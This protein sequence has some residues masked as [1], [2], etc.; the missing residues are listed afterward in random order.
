MSMSKIVYKITSIFVLLLLLSC[1]SSRE[2]ES[3]VSRMMFT[4]QDG[5]IKLVVLDPGHFHASLLQKFP[6]RQVNDTV[7]VYAPKGDELNQYL[8]SIESYNQRL[9]NPT[10]WYTKVYDGE[11][12]LEKM[13]EEKKGNVV[14]LAGNN[15]KKTRYIY[16]SIKA[17]LHVLSDKPM[18]INRESFYLLVDAYEDAQANELQLYD[19]MTERYEILNTLTRE[20]IGNSELFGQLQKGTPEEQSVVMENVHHYFKDVSGS[21]LIRPAWFYDVEQ[22]GEA[23]ADVG[24]HL[25]DL[26]NWQCFADE[27]IDY[28]RDVDVIYAH[29]W[30]TILTL[31]DF[32]RSTGL[33]SFPEFLQRYVND[34][35]ELEVFGNGSINYQVKGINIAVSALW[36]YEAPPGGGDTYSA[37]IKGT[38]ASIEIKQ[39][40][41]VNYIKELFIEKTPLIDEQTFEFHLTEM[42]EKLQVSYPYVSA[43]KVSSSRY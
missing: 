34:N 33:I 11:D 20:L 4:G 15:K 3:S 10:S 5:E 16:H 38:K 43:R 6:Q 9:E 1:I 12:Y 30:P 25:V 14:I 7:Y 40:S 17:G 24:T 23:I 8:V 13:V 26:V 21:T 2:Q 36:N 37:R 28:E 19:V 27:V 35:S 29:H 32:T 22:Q 18:V 39:D 31:E 41:S 42:V